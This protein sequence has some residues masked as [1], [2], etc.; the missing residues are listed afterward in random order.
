MP[1]IGQ[2][3]TTRFNIE[4]LFISRSKSALNFDISTSKRIKITPKEKFKSRGEGEN[5]SL[6][7]W[8]KERILRILY[9]SSVPPPQKKKE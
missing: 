9:K 2:N 4:I 3:K 5:D 1:K 7:C 8:S 6:K